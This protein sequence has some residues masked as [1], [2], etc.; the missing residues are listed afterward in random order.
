MKSISRAPRNLL[1]VSLLLLVDANAQT[2]RLWGMTPMGGAEDKG[3]LFRIDADGTDFTVEHHFS[4]TSGWAPEG[5]LCLADNGKLYGTT[6]FGGSGSPAAGTLFSFDPASGTYTTLVNF[7]N[8]NGGFGW[9]GLIATPEGM[10][11]GATYGG[12]ST[13]GSIFS[14]DPTSDTYT[15]RYNLTQATDGGGITSVLYRHT[16]GQ[17][18]GCAAYGG[19]NNAGTLFRFD[20][21]TNVFTKL[22]DLGGGPNGKTP[23]GNLCPGGNGW[24]YGTTFE[25]GT[26]NKGTLFKY[27]PGTN[28]FVKLLDFTGTNGQGPWNAPVRVGPDKLY[29]TAA[30]GGPNNGN[31]VIF[32][33]APGTDAFE[34]EYVFNI[35]DGGLLTGNVMLANDGQ[36]YG[37]GGFGGANFQGSIYRLD[38]ATSTMTTL[39]SFNGPT[40][41]YSPRGD[42]IQAGTATGIA[43]N[44]TT[45]AFSVSPNPTTG[46]VRIQVS[47]TLAGE[48]RLRITNM[49][50][51]VVLE[52]AVLGSIHTL[53][54]N[55]TPGSYV[56]SMESEHGRSVQRVVVE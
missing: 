21:S 37:M 4:E 53:L 22:H 18:Y 24:F 29:G 16:D 28:T 8:S 55:A 6:N 27:S 47:G 25:G 9:G 34:L 10:L 49:L 26:D 46:L 30:N 50:G 42:L 41:G 56:L 32:S 3:T 13:G 54:L 31:G 7:N 45:P 17:L 11:Y 43:A 19:V 36:L 38:P 14:L 2:P 35:L 33:I 44:H 23:Y 48:I 1:L 5:T 51:Q 40:D 15:V 20:P 39:H 12:S 52:E